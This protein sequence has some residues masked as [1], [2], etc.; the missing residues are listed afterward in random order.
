MQLKISPYVA[1]RA[2]STLVL[3][4][5]VY[6]HLQGILIPS[7]LLRD[8]CSW[9][10]F[11]WLTAASRRRFGTIDRLRLTDGELARRV[12]TGIG[13]AGLLGCWTAGLVADG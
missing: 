6:T 2:G 10:R 9:Y 8:P 12:V 11:S 1:A 5:R 4:S 7:L 3:P 13:R